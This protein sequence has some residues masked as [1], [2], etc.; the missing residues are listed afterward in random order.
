M[1][2]GQK[3]NRKY[4]KGRFKKKIVF[5]AN[6]II[7]GVTKESA[8]PSLLIPISEGGPNGPPSGTEPPLD[9]RPVCK[10]DKIPNL[11]KVLRE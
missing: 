9:L 10:F 1:V 8:P 4:R 5:G 2:Q 11:P 7:Q 6:K 3:T